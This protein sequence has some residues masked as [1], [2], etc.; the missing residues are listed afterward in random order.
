MYNDS[1]LLY[2]MDFDANIFR[3]FYPNDLVIE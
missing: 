1:E 3:F 2:D